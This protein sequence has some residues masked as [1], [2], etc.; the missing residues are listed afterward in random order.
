MVIFAVVTA[1]EVLYYD[2][3]CVLFPF[4]CQRVKV[5]FFGQDHLERIYS[6][7]ADHRYTA[8]VKLY[9]PLYDSQAETGSFYVDIR[10]DIRSYQWTASVPAS[11]RMS[12]KC[13]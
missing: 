5:L 4:G 1:H 7:V 11:V 12:T 3:V 10:L 13:P 6:A 2:F 8:P 9:Y